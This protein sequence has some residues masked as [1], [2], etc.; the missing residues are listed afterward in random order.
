MDPLQSQPA[1][2]LV[3]AAKTVQVVKPGHKSEAANG[4]SINATALAFIRAFKKARA[5]QQKQRL[6]GSLRHSTE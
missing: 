4:E 2:K 1:K 6:R 3:K 5:E